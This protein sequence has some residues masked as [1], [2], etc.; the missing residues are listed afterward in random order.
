MTREE[1]F[2]RRRAAATRTLY[3]WSYHR[4][5][6]CARPCVDWQIQNAIVIAATNRVERV[7]RFGVL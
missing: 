1:F 4:L 7:Q 3:D 5:P 2:R 6:G